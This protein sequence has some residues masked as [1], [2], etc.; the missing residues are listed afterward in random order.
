MPANMIPDEANFAWLLKQYPHGY[1]LD[2][3]EGQTVDGTPLIEPLS[4]VDCKYVSDSLNEARSR[5]T[6]NLMLWFF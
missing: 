1:S 6:F 3:E 4:P 2:C 5:N